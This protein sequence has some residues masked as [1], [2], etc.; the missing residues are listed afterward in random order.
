VVNGRTKCCV[1][2]D[3]IVQIVI[4]SVT[5]DVLGSRSGMVRGSQDA[6]SVTGGRR[7]RGF[8]VL[9]VDRL[10]RV[11]EL[12]WLT[13]DDLSRWKLAEALVEQERTWIEVTTNEPSPEDEA[14]KTRQDT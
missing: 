14:N 5:R 10:H 1:A 3:C 9:L 12:I 8:V 7:R 11:V 13:S 6:C 2:V 4:G